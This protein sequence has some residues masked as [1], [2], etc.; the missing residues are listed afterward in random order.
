LSVTDVIGL[1]ILSG[2]V[3]AELR[4]FREAGPLQP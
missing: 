4:A 3:A 1:Y 2:V